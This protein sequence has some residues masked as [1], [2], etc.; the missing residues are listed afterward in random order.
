VQSPGLDSGQYRYLR[1]FSAPQPVAVPRSPALFFNHLSC[2][3]LP[4]YIHH[5][6]NLD[7]SLKDGLPS[8]QV[9]RRVAADP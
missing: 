3:I 9:G 1:V 5:A 8:F 2:C 4:S 7:F 6:N